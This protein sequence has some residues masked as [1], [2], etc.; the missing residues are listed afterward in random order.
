MEVTDSGVSIFLPESE[1][2]FKNIRNLQDIHLIIHSIARKICDNYR[3][4]EYPLNTSR[5]YE[6][7]EEYFKDH[8]IDHTLKSK[9]DVIFKAL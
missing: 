7:W 8:T 1:H 3:I 2:I 5:G 4:E 9:L 6:T